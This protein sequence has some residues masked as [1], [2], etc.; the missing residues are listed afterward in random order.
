M[1][2]KFPWQQSKT[3]EKKDIKNKKNLLKDEFKIA[4]KV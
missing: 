1:K 3:F 2:I 4:N